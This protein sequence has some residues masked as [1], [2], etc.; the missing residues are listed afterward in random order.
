MRGLFQIGDNQNHG[1]FNTKLWSNDWML[2]GYPH[3]LGN[4]DVGLP[5]AGFSTKFRG[6]NGNVHTFS[7]S[8]TLLGL[9]WHT[10]KTG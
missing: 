5:M 3:D 1:C 10:L 9:Q 2:N 7:L 8:P 6:L 4:L